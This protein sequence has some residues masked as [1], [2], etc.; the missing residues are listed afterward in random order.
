MRTGD[1]DRLLICMIVAAVVDAEQDVDQRG[2]QL[3]DGDVRLTP[4]V[5]RLHGVEQPLAGTVAETVF[6][7]TAGTEDSRRSPDFASLLRETR[8]AGRP[9]GVGLL[10]AVQAV[11]ETIQ[12]ASIDAHSIRRDTADERALIQVDEPDMGS[13]RDRVLF[14]KREEVLRERGFAPALFNALDPLQQ[15]AVVD[16]EQVHTVVRR[17]AMLKWSQEVVQELVGGTAP[18]GRRTVKVHPHDQA[19]LQPAFHDSFRGR[20]P[21]HQPEARNLRARC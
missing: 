20:H 15:P 21:G 4:K 13:G 16:G 2:A 18:P 3:A 10:A 8:P 5:D 1:A 7:E 9:D 6:R 12:E 17:G 11:H 19:V 14:E